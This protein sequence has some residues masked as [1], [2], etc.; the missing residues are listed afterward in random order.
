MKKKT[1]AE[2]KGGIA[3]PSQRAAAFSTCEGFLFRPQIVSIGGGGH[4]QRYWR[5][6][7]WCSSPLFEPFFFISYSSVK[8]DVGF[9]VEFGKHAQMKMVKV[10][11]SCSFS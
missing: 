10:W 11:R 9:K 6:C 4:C 5:A 2:E 8:L 3:T 1:E 7:K